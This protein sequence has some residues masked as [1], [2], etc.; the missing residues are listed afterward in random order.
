MWLEILSAPP[1]R[2]GS[3][4]RDQK[5]LRFKPVAPTTCGGRTST[6][7]AGLKP[8][9]QRCQAGFSLATKAEK[10]SLTQKRAVESRCKDAQI[11]D[12]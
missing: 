8:E 7:C 12:L 9:A 2:R 3:T 10:S 1:A 5:V 4:C 6:L 11:A